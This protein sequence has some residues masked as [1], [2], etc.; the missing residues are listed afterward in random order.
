MTS[1]DLNTLVTIYHPP[2]TIYSISLPCMIGLY[3]S[4]C[5][6]PL[7]TFD[8]VSLTKTNYPDRNSLGFCSANYYLNHLPHHQA[9]P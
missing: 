5:I 7:E 6:L 2:V 1:L 4:S 8:T 9:L 3:L